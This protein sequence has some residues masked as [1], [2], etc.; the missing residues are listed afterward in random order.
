MQSAKRVDVLE[1][2]LD[3]ELLRPRAPDRDV[4]LGAQL[5]LLHVRLGGADRAQQRAQLHRVV[6]RLVG[7]AQVRLA[8][9]LHQRHARP[10]QVDVRLPRLVQLVARVDELARVLFEMHAADADLARTDLEQTVDAHRQVVLADLVALGQVG[11]H[12]VLAVELGVTRDVA[13][14]RERRFQARRYRGA[15]RHRQDA[16]QTEADLAH[17]CVRCCI[18]RSHR[19][20]AEHLRLRL[21]LDMDLHADHHFPAAHPPHPY[22]LPWRGE[23]EATPVRISLA[24]S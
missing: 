21:R 13:V 1:L 2:G 4:R 16:G 12:V 8:D 3:A 7:G 18:Q 14:E 6:A 17:V 20:A 19:A 23:G 5:A 22:P 15:V 10:V 9:D 11:I 24:S